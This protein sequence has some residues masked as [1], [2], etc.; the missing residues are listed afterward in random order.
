MSNKLTKRQQKA[1]TFRKNKKH[2]KE[3]S[4]E[5]NPEKIE[6]NFKLDIENN[7]DENSIN[8]IESN[9]GS[10]KEEKR[11]NGNEFMEEVEEEDS[12]TSET[13]NT[14]DDNKPSSNNKEKNGKIKQTKPNTIRFIVFVANL[15]YDTKNEALSKHF[16]SAGKPISIRLISDKKTNKQ[17]GFAF[18]EFA[19]SQELNRALRFHHSIFKNRQIKVELTAGGGGNKSKTRLNK[20]NE[21]RKKLNNERNKFY[22]TYVVPK[23]SK[24]DL[25][26]SVIKT[27]SPKESSTIKNKNLIVKK[28]SRLKGSNS[29]KPTK[30][31]KFGGNISD[32]DDMNI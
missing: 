21:K 22:K 13:G 6:Q 27:T 4:I 16:E 2:R 3:I 14:D 9:N 25:G 20:I 18:V 31:R 5:E 17:K 28:P 24:N 26:E 32:N 11:N 29:I 30:V 7:K 1:F 12:V 15:P 10:N 19:T 8:F 23:K